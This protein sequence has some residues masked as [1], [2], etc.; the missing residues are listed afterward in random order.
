[1]E[2]G[3]YLLGPECGAG[4]WSWD[5][6]VLPQGGEEEEDGEGSV[7]LKSAGHRPCDVPFW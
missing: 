6:V 1:M 4:P 2:D 7:A 5:G 3:K